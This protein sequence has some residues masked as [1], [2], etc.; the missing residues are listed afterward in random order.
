MQTIPADFHISVRAWPVTLSS[1]ADPGP[2][3]EVDAF[4]AALELKDGQGM[5]SQSAGGRGHFP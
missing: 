5:K 4:L 2:T 3:D 1:V